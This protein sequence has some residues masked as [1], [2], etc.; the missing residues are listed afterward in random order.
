MTLHELRTSFVANPQTH[1]IL[2]QESQL[3]KSI[4]VFQ[5]IKKLNYLIK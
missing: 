4:I 3:E 2:L 1:D 5:P